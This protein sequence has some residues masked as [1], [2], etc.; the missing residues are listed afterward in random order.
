M[1]RSDVVGSLLRPAY[2]KEAQFALCFSGVTHPEQ[3]DHGVGE[4]ETSIRCALSGMPIR[5][6]FV[7]PDLNELFSL[8]SGR[9]SADKQVV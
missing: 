3:L 4:K 1:Y 6:R 7:Q 8:R 5:R 9:G 2:L